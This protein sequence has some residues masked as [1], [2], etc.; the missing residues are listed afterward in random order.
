MYD[1]SM[2]KTRIFNILNSHNEKIKKLQEYNIKLIEYIE[3]LESNLTSWELNEETWDQNKT[4]HHQ[5]TY[6]QV[7]ESK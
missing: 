3:S 4:T 5:T 1:Y 7:T 2:D 6:R